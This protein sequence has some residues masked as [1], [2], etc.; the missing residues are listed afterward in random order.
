MPIL[1]AAASLA[2]DWQ[3]YQGFRAAAIS[4]WQLPLHRPTGNVAPNDTPAEPHPKIIKARITNISANRRAATLRHAGRGMQSSKSESS[5]QLRTLVHQ[6]AA[7]TGILFKENRICCSKPSI[8]DAAV[9]ACTQSLLTVLD[10]IHNEFFNTTTGTDLLSGSPS[11]AAR[12]RKLLRQ[13]L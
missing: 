1:A 6:L 9:H 11:A 12:R 13:K 2:P 5:S 3:H 7:T 8:G 4:G 10:Q